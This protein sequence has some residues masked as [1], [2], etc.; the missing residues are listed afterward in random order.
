ML[1]GG[2]AAL[3]G[4]TVLLTSFLSGIFGMAGGM[5]LLGVLL[6]LLDVAPAM[7]LFGVTQLASNGWRAWLWRAYIRWPIMAGYAVGSVAMFGVMTAIAF[8][9]NKGMIFLGLGLMAFVVDFLPRALQPDITRRFAPM[10]CGALIMVL[11]LVAGAA[12]NV[13]DVFFQQSTLDRK[14]IVATKA[15]TQVLAHLM[16][17]LYFGSVASMLSEELP[18]WSYLGC[19]LTAF[20]GTSLAAIVLHRMSDARFRVW[21]MV[22]IRSVSLCFVV[23][24]AWL[25]VR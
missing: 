11:Q 18:W 3:V 19:I 10:L 9:P 20:L 21:S 12:G 1:T 13:L 17:V 24:G 2:L 7:V 5:I 25:L 8:L 16:R 15:A 6:A 23:A 22:I 14:T 4:A